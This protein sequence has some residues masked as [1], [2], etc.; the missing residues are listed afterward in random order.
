MRWARQRWRA[1][2]GKHSSIARM[3]P[4][5]PSETTSSGSPSPRARRSWKNARTVSTSSF[6]P[7]IRRQQDLA[8]VLADAPGGQHRLAP[9]ARTEPLGDAVDEQVDDRV[10]GKIALEKASYSAH[11]RS[12]ISLTAARDRSLRPVR[13]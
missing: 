11:S 4:G 6:E 12:V 8:P 2:R 3:M 1:E 7:A 5:A 9:L 10:L 13:R